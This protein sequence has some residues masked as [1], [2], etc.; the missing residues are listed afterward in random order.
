VALDLDVELGDAR[1]AQGDA[2]VGV[3]HCRVVGVE[4]GHQDERC[5]EEAAALVRPWPGC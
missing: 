4:A 5:D 1:E 2:V 3:L